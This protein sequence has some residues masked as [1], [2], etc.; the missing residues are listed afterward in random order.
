MKKFFL[1]FFILC[2]FLANANTRRYRI[3]ITDN[4][5][6]T[7]MIGW[8]QVSGSNTKIYYDSIDYGINW[9]NYAFFKSKET[10]VIDRGMTNSFT[11]LD[12]LTPNTNYYFLIKDSEGISSRYWFKTAPNTNETMS[13]IAGGDSR[14]NRIP[15]QFANTMVSKLKPTA[16]FFGGDMTN[17]DSD[18]EWQEW[19][20]DWQ[21]TIASDGR[22]FPI[23][24]ARGNHEFNNNRIPKLFNIPNVNSYYK[25]TFG[26]NLYSIYTLNSEISAGGS[27]AAWLKNTLEQDNSIWKSA[28]YHKPM[29]PHVTYKSEGNDEY[30]NW[31]KLFY[32]YKV[33]LVFESDSHTVKTTWP[34]KPCLFGINC[35]E[36][37]ERDDINGTIY[38]GEG[39]WGAPLRNSNDNKTWSRDFGSFNQFKWL[40]VSNTK[41]ELKTIIIED[42]N[43]I[44]EINNITTCL[45][46]NG[47]NIWNPTNGDTVT[48]TNLNLET[49]NITFTSVADND[50]IENGLNTSIQ[51]EAFDTDGNI[52]F[53]EFYIN[54]ELIAV[55]NTYPFETNYD[56]DDGFY[57][58]ES[59][60]Y[61]NDNLTNNEAIRLYIG[62]FDIKLFPNP[63]KEIISFN[64]L[65]KSFTNAEIFIYSING[66]LIYNKKL[67]G[68]KINLEE[69]SSGIYLLRMVGINNKVIIKKIIKN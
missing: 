8:E 69:L 9:S 28:Q 15:R 67:L 58:L 65:G 63:F 37:F 19:F 16:V 11:K 48:I 44:S 14:N 56:F 10:E 30:N 45:V 54:G 64:N 49:P 62:N 40:C 43:T 31:A 39:C 22:M 66:K 53:V 2:F 7:I 59:I 12:G 25:I 13:F 46:P 17:D 29:K 51:T 26:N 4:P 50:F 3:V 47:V 42:P 35:D 36:G 41:I 57:I 34:I 55:D 20:D 24:P 33:K 6:T 38:V 1:F 32:D 52:L 61:D 21:L 60:A 68:K 27:Q 18:I 5:S 23:I